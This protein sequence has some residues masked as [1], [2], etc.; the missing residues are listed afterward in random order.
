M[1]IAVVDGMGGGLGAQLVAGLT[2]SGNGRYEVIALGTNALATNNMLRAG[3][4][5]GA[6]GENAIMVSIQNAGIVVGPLGIVV[7]NALMGEITPRIAEAVA[8]CRAR[9]VLIP[10]SQSHFEI[11][12]IGTDSQG[13]TMT[14]L[15][16]EAI[17]RVCE[18]AKEENG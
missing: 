7:P 16:K 1:V 11:V 8:M 4:A 13:K 18:L 17:A 14:V 3:A 12:G 9:K 5:R 15:I 10:V 2:G 6:T